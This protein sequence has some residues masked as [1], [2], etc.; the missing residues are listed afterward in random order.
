MTATDESR[1]TLP[2]AV[3]MPGAAD[4]ARVPR[5]ARARELG[6]AW[7]P[8]AVLAL[9]LLATFYTLYFAAGLFLPVFF[10]VFISAVLRPLVRMLSVI[11]I[12]EALGALFVLLVLVLALV[13]ASSY[14]ADPVERW[15]EQLPRVQRELEARLWQVRQSI[16]QAE[17]AA[18]DL[19]ELAPGKTGDED[20][21]AVA[22]RERS[23]LSQLFETTLLSFV[24]LLIVL[25]LAFFMLAQDPERRHQMFHRLASDAAPTHDHGLLHAVEL[26]LTRYL[27]ISAAIYL[28]LG[29]LTALTMTL[30]QMPNPILW[31]G[32]A[33]VLGFSPYL[34][35]MVLVCCIGAVSLLTFDDWWGILAPPLAY[36]ALTVV[37]GYFVTPTVLGR[38]LTV[39]PVAVF[40]SMLLW[41][42]MWGVP[43]AFLAVPILVVTLT[44]YRH[45]FTPGDAPGSGVVTT[46]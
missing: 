27:R 40:L 14:L 4:A 30:L 25:A 28:A 12:N 21:R 32:L 24:Q 6:R 7:A 44:V 34:G 41:T 2:P 5:S 3:R 17:A 45:L 22:V 19:K 39:P 37:E 13:S 46:A 42:W 35:P 29:V 16:A 20:G 11:G 15:V 10:A 26:T 31:G 43:G 9:A 38:S 33:T 23:L 36:G 18:A 1:A 8:V